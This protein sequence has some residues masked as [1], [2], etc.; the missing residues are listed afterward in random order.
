M[1]VLMLFTVELL[2]EFAHQLL[3]SVLVGLASLLHIQL[4]LNVVHL[5]EIGVEVL[6]V[7]QIFDFTYYG[8][9]LEVL[10][11]VAEDG[12]PLAFGCELGHQTIVLVTS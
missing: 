4:L 7:P 8:L 10:L 12:F 9:A 5:V 2:I 6:F 3:G 1:G 11:V